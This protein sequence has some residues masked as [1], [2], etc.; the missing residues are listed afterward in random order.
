VDDRVDECPGVPAAASRGGDCAAARDACR[1]LREGATDLSGADLRGCRPEAPVAVQTALL[2]QGADLSCA[3]LTLVGGGAASAVDLSETTVEGARLE[4]RAAGPL[5]LD[6]SRTTLRDASLRV[7]GGV[8]LFGDETI[9]ERVGVEVDPGGGV[10]A[11]GGPAV[12]L[13]RSNLRDVVLGE[14]AAG[15]PGRVRIDASD[16]RRSRLRLPVL[17]LVGVRLRGSRVDAAELSVHG[18]EVRGTQIRTAYGTFSSVE[19]TD[20]IFDGCADLHFR[21]AGLF[22]VDVPRCAPGRLRV[23]GSE[24]LGSRLLGGLDA[25]EG[26]IAASVLGGGPESTFRTRDVELDG[27]TFCDPGAGAFFGGSLRCVR[28]DARAFMEGA[29]VC[30]GGAHLF[31]RGCPALELA[32]ECG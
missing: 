21:D 18:E 6:V 15:R 16:V 19:L 25:F 7:G 14:E 27:V 5:V 28:C 26:E 8:R 30:L 10:E 9:L 12:E 3:S 20:V 29:A 11:P 2:L 13:R 23:V 31:E 32:P 4:V 1:R 22:D 24:V 17:D